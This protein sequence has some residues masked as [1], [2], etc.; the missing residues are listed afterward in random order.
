MFFSLLLYVLK[1][2]TCLFYMRS[3]QVQMFIDVVVGAVVVIAIDAINLQL[4]PY[5]IL[6]LARNLLSLAY[7]YIHTHL[8]GNISHASASA[9]DDGC[10]RM[11]CTAFIA[12]NV[13]HPIVHVHHILAHIHILS[14]GWN[15]KILAYMSV[16]VVV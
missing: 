14:R 8:Y 10:L 16:F 11:Y 9:S 7:I 15:S 5:P 12:S 6:P 4:Y 3:A 2:C 1:L 13:F